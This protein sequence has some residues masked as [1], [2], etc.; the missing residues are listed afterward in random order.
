VW[1]E[2]SLLDIEIGG[3]AAYALASPAEPFRPAQGPESAERAADPPEE[4]NFACKW[5]I[6]RI[7]NAYE[8]MELLDKDE[9]AIFSQAPK[10]E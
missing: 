1:I 8:W 4:R 7:V 2:Q 9:W 5:L 6:P 10:L 3:D